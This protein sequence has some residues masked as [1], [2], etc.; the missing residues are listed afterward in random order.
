MHL[1]DLTHLISPDM[2]VY[3]GMEPPV[4]N[5]ACS[6]AAHGFREKKITMFSHIGTHIDA[7]AHMLKNGQ[8]LDE[9]PLDTFFGKAFLWELPDDNKG[10]IGIKDLMAEREEI[11]RADFLLINTGWDKYWKNDDYFAGYPVL[12]PETAD[13]L[14]QISL[15]GVGLDTISADRADCSDFPVHNSLL[16]SGM[17]IIENLSGLGQLNRSRFMFSCLP[18]K[19]EKADGSP[20]R[21][22]ALLNDS[23]RDTGLE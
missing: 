18:L 23:G 9:L 4:L 19:L 16:K 10:T 12:S 14:G 1:I 6:I 5:N 20:V 21:A 8:T 13:W 2:P 22:I 15:K 7:P 11:E 3:P 17:V